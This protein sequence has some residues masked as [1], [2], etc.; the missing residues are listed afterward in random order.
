MSVFKTGNG[1]LVEISMDSVAKALIDTNFDSDAFTILRRI[2]EPESEQAIPRHDK[3]YG[4]H[5]ARIKINDF[6]F[7]H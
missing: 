6:F 5:C 7:K 1:K 2:I 4:K 3:L